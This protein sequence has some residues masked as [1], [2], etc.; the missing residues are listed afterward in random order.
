LKIP[1]GKL[2]TYGK[3]ASKIG[4]AN[5][6]GA[7]SAGIGRILFV[8]HF[9]LSHYSH[10]SCKHWRFYV[11]ERT[12]RRY[13]GLGKRSKRR[14][15]CIANFFGGGRNRCLYLYKRI[16][17]QKNSKNKNNVKG[18]KIKMNRRQYKDRAI[19]A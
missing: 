13:H 10:E 12:P 5:A 17:I 2:S 3:I 8:S 11:G 15:G 9:P 7:I 19:G 6:S 16:L 1:P 18:V 14:F 4:N